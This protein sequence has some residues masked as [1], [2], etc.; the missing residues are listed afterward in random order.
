MTNAHSRTILVRNGWVLSMDD[1]VGDLTS[2]DVLI[3]NGRIS[4]VAEHVTAPSGQVE[5]IDATGCLVLPGLVDTHR[6]MWQG[7]LRGSAPHST[8]MDY[9][10]QV[11]GQIGPAMRPRDFYVGNMLSA[12]SALNAGV[13]AIQDVSNAQATPEHSDAITVALQESGI[14]A[15]FAY[16]KDFLAIV[17]TGT[18]LPEDV[19]RVRADLLADDDALVTMALVTEPGDEAGIVH[20]AKLARELSL[21]TTMHTSGRTPLT[22]LRDLDALLPKTTFIHGNGLDAGSL[23]LIRE[24]GGSLS[25]SAAIEMMM[26]HGTPMFA[27]A[28]NAGVPISLSVDVEVT[29]ASDLFGQMRAAYQVARYQQLT[30]HT[31]EYEVTVSP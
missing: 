24:A 28:L 6:H 18:A 15:V 10:E 12:R 22:I 17:A 14:R 26:G 1:A 11:C 13:T 9:L 8:L 16:G 20:N 3:E 23:A 4:A 7:G 30:Q 19:R 25:I 5:E 27:E 31:T 21:P 2:G 29:A